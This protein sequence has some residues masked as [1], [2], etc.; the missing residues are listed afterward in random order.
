V[1]D[2]IP[3]RKSNSVETKLVPRQLSKPAM[4]ILIIIAL[5]MGVFLPSLNLFKRSQALL[6]FMISSNKLVQQI[7]SILSF[8]TIIFSGKDNSFYLF[9]RNFVNQI[10]NNLNMYEALL[11][12]ATIA[13]ILLSLKLYF[14]FAEK[15]GM[16]AGVNHRS[17]H[18]KP[19]ITG[20]GFIFYISYVFYIISFVFSTWDAP[21]PLFIGISILAIVSFIDDLKDLWFFIRLVVQILAVILMLYQIYIEFSMEPFAM[22]ASLLII[23]AIV[24]LIFSVGFVNLYNFMDGLNG[25]MVG[26]TI[27]ALAI[28]AL[29]DFFVVDFVDDLLLVYTAIPTLIF[30]FFNA[31]RQAI[32][33]AG[34]VGAIVLGFVMVYMLVSLLMQTANVVYIFIFASIY[35]EAGMTVMQRLL[36]GQNIFKPHRIHLFQLLCNEHKHH[37]VKISAFYALNQLV[38]GA[39]IVTMNYYELNDL[40]QNLTVIGLFTVETIL[41]FIYKRKLMGGHLLESLKNNK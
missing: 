6:G 39:I 19:V 5:K 30:A 21:W 18:T 11:V 37:H 33:F 13:V 16:L 14:P 15:K 9:I 36:A 29:I 24:G 17:S 3:L 4:R 26:I 40:V 38:F 1:P 28:F 23:L 35:L 41:Y 12:I 25:M 31:R 8:K 7:M 27:S 34:D 22:N 10:L 2:F 20:A 32:C